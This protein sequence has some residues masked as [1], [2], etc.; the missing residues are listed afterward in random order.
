M[1]YWLDDTETPPN[2]LELE[3]EACQPYSIGAILLAPYTFEKSLNNCN[4]LIHST[5][6]IQKQIKSRFKLKPIFYTLPITGNPT[7]PPYILDNTFNLWRNVGIHTIGDLYIKCIFASFAQSQGK[8]N[9]TGSS[10]FRY[11][12][13][14]YTSAKFRD[15]H[16]LLS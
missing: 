15:F 3:R 5:E 2:W 7:V 13:I 10:F 1:A 4:M 6:R 12:Q 9:L 16:R 8:Y 11:L 14:R